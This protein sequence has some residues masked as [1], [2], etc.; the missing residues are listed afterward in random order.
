MV[1]NSARTG[2]CSLINSANALQLNGIISF[3][4]ANA[5]SIQKSNFRF[6]PCGFFGGSL[7]GKREAKKKESKIFV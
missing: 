5:T 4:S 3:R 2:E 1:L 6:A 7:F